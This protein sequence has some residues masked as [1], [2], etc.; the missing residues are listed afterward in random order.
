MKFFYCINLFAM[1]IIDLELFLIKNKMKQI[2]LA[3]YLGLTQSYVSAWVNPKRPVKMPQKHIQKILDAKCFDVSMIQEV[4]KTR[5]T[6]NP[7]DSVSM[8][9]EVFDLLKNQSETILSQQR[10]IEMLAGKG[11]SA[12][13]A[14]HAGCADAG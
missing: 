8:D 1:Y 5:K 10:T 13:P 12:R 14:D 7:Q 4:K 2:D 3:Q 6:T 11:E 9:R